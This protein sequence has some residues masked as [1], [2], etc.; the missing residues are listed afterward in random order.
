MPVRWQRW[1]RAVGAGWFRL[2]EGK[3]GKV[4][5]ARPMAMVRLAHPSAP[6]QYYDS[7]KATW[8]SNGYT[9]W[10]AAEWQA[11]FGKQPLEGRKWE[12]F[13]YLIPLYDDDDPN[14]VR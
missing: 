8:V 5:V 3:G 11:K 13:G 4:S 7:T 6:G 9:T 14:K 2:P 12:Q 1:T 10:T